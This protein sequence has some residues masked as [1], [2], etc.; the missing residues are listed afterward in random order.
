MAERLAGRVPPNV[1]VAPLYGQLTPAEQDAVIAPAPAARRKVVLATSIAQTSLT[2]EGVR[3]VIDCGLSRLP[4]YDPGTGLTNL[5]TR[6]VSKAAAEQRRGRAGRTEPGI[7]YR[8][9]GEVQ[10]GAL[11]P[12]DRPEILDADLAGLVLDLAGWGVS[13]P[14]CL[15]SS[16]IRRPSPT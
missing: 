11:V 9:W 1:D 7:C 12:F 10:Q 14:G 4:A 15:A 6:R 3:I 16:S 5:E 13:D 2:I 8:L